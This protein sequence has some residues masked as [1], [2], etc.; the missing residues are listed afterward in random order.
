MQCLIVLEAVHTR[1]RRQSLPLT[2]QDRGETWGRG[3][4]ITPSLQIGNWGQRDLGPEFYRC[5]RPAAP[6]E[7][8]R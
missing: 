8:N 2:R 1:Y 7:N 5:S 4:I 3:S 6:T